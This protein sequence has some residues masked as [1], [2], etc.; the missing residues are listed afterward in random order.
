MRSKER[1]LLMPLIYT[2]IATVVWG[3]AFYFFMAKLTSWEVGEASK[4]L[5]E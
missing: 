5:S 1:L 4:V 2:I 3:F